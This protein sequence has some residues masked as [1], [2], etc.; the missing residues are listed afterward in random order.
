M[1]WFKYV[2]DNFV[3]WSHGKQKLGE[4]LNQSNGI[5]KNIQFTMEI[6][7]ESHLPFLDIDIYRKPDSLLGHKVHRKPTHTNQ[8]L[9]QN[10][11]HHP[12]N[13]TS[14]LS[15]LI[16]RA[17]ALC[18]Q[19]SLTQELVFVTAVFLKKLHIAHSRFDEQ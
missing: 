17:K 12:A 11:H 15:S 1:C 10:S 2:D 13:K 9:Q 8:Y 16:H 19:D 4:F 5:H 6:D 7:E 18:D 14:F 3:I